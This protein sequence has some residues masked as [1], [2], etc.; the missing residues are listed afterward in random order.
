[1]F[2]IKICFSPVSLFYVNLVVRPA[3]E[4]R[5]VEGKFF[6][7]YTLLPLKRQEGGIESAVPDKSWGLQERTEAVTIVS[8]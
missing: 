8:W 6:Q 2:K 1:M 3:K 4:P 7:P 5:K